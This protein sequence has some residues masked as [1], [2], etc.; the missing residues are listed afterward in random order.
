[1]Y[2]IRP[3]IQAY[4]KNFQKALKYQ[5]DF[6]TPAKPSARGVSRIFTHIQDGLSENKTIFGR[7]SE[8][9]IPMKKQNA[10]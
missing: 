8:D 3:T 10:I 7:D 6:Y 5:V 2:K 4:R 9:D 1:M